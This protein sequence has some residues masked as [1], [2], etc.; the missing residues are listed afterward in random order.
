MSARADTVRFDPPHDLDMPEMQEILTKLTVVIVS[1]CRQLD[2]A[3]SDEGPNR[4]RI[5]DYTEK[6]RKTVSDLRA[7]RERLENIAADIG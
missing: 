6:K 3:M 1:E 4:D 5:D 7:I 2:R